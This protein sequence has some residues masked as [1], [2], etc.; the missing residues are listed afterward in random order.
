MVLI[1]FETNKK[2]RSRST[3]ALIL[4]GGAIGKVF[5]SVQVDPLLLG[6]RGG[7]DGPRSRQEK[8]DHV[9]KNYKLSICKS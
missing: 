3:G 2:K 7:C 4:F 8:W 6:K 1:C 5:P 9:Y